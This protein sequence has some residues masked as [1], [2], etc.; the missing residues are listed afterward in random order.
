MRRRERSTVGGTGM[1]ARK[2]KERERK[3]DGCVRS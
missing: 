1:P 2:W 3:E